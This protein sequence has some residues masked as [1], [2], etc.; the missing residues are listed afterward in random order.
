MCIVK[1]MFIFLLFFKNDYVEEN[2]ANR[3]ENVSLIVP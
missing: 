2:S 1:D 3:E